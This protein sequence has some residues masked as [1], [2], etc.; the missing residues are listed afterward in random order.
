[1]LR[2][3][4]SVTTIALLCGSA[5]SQTSTPGHIGAKQVLVQ[6]KFGGGIF[7][8][9]IDQNGTE[10]ILAESQLLP[11]GN[12]L[13]AVETFDQATGKILTVVSKKETA[14]EVDVALGIAGTSVGLVAHGQDQKATVYHLLNPLASNKYTGLWTPPHFDAHYVLGGLSRSQG[15]STTAF[16][17]TD[18]IFPGYANYVFGSDVA[19][20]AFRPMVKMT[21]RNFEPY[22]TP[23]LALDTKTNTAILAQ[24][25][26]APMSVPDI[27]MVNLT[28]G[29]FTHFQIDVGG[30]GH[31][32]GLAVDSE[33]GI[34]CTTTEAD[35]SIELY[36][37]KKQTGVSIVLPGAQTGA[38]VQFD[39]IHKLFL[40]AQPVSGTASGSSIQVYDTKGTLVES[41]N[42]FSFSNR[43]TAIPL[44]IA[45]NPKKRS[46]FVQSQVN[47][48][49]PLV[50]QS[51]TY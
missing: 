5:A 44:Y 21:D 8:Y 49:E 48:D 12:T 7:D 28:T 29:K 9:D 36:D 13:S 22:L 38:D 24:D 18:N 35:A 40:V 32:L 46:G 23:L 14:L 30:S 6:P 15:S 31:V 34:A 2:V 45:L 19:H 20:G 1:M 4:F 11:N 16:W 26:G 10:G 33:D 3:P 50:L 27:G 42:G 41:V 43:F 25:D 37:L 39:P 51:F 17:V 47:A